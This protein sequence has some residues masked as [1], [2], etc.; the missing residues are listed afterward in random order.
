MLIP[1]STGRWVV[2]EDIDLAPLDVLSVLRPLLE[3]RKLFIPERG[4]EIV[5]ASTF[6]LFA[7]QSLFGETPLPLSCSRITLVYSL[8]EGPAGTTRGQHS[9]LLSSF[10]TKVTVEPLSADE[11]SQ[12]LS[13]Q[14]PSLSPQIPTFLSTFHAIR[15][16]SSSSFSTPHLE[17]LPSADFAPTSLATGRFLSVMSRSPCIFF[18]ILC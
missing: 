16:W 11:L 10:W 2:I 14:F 13:K 9:H 4:E 5:A 6:Q 12:V 17:D 15:S 7:T 8:L 18:L 1:S 3:T